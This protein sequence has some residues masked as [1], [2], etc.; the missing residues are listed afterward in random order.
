[1]QAFE[2]NGDKY[3]KKWSLAT[4]GDYPLLALCNWDHFG[5]VR[6]TPLSKITASAMLD[7]EPPNP[8]HYRTPSTHTLP[9]TQRH[10]GKPKSPSRR[11]TRHN[12]ATPTSLRASLATS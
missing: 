9:A 11:R 1:M 3:D 2:I 12:S 7:G 6:A 8:T 10:F 5:Q 4:K